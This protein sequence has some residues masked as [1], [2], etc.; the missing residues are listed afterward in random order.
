MGNATLTR[1]QEPEVISGREHLNVQDLSVLFS[2]MNNFEYDADRLIHL[3]PKLSDDDLLN[4]QAYAK[5]VSKQ[6]WR[7]ENAVCAEITRRAE[8]RGDKAAVV[9]QA[10]RDMG[11]TDSQLYRNGQIHDTFGDDI[12]AAQNIE[13]KGF[14]EEALRH[15]EDPKAA[16]AVIADKKAADPK[17]TTRHARADVTAMKQGATAEEVE[18]S[19][20]LTVRISNTTAEI[21]RQM[22]LRWEEDIDHSFERICRMI[23]QQLRIEVP[24]EVTE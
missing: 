11:I 2:D 21:L 3:L 16:L 18:N 9:S 23:A 14:Y 17:Y 13:E 24:K 12:Q 22:S 19:R 7:V 1:N 20:L 8:A 15:K 4:V 10:A 6:A 5:T